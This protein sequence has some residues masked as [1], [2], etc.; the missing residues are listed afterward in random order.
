MPD[1]TTGVS[2]VICVC[3][4]K[5]APT[6]QKAA[7]YIVRNI[8]ARHYKLLVPDPELESFRAI[9]PDAFEVIAES[10]YVGHL[11]EKIAARLP[12]ANAGRKGWYLQQFIKMAAASAAGDDD[13]ILIW[14]AD[15]V[16]LKPLSFVDER[17]RIIYYQGTEHHAPYFELIKRLIGLEKAADFSFIAQC[18]PV[19]VRWLRELFAELEQK[20]GTR[21]EDAIIAGIDFSQA[22]GFSEYETMGTFIAFHHRAEI[23]FS[24][25]RWWRFGNRLV[26]D[27]ELLTERKARALARKFDFISFEQWERRPRYMGLRRLLAR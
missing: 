17:G 19:K 8:K 14:D 3:S 27:I 10:R 18:F 26:G 5:D 20:A 15:T 23:T 16:P 1:R 11:G 13:I 9:S 25:N 7:P 6:W 22:S 24:P 4:R 21:W 2:E 12:A